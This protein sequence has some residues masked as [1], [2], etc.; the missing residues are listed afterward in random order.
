MTVIKRK[1]SPVFPSP[2]SGTNFYLNAGNFP[3]KESI[4]LSVNSIGGKLLRT[5]QFTTG[6]LGEGFAN[7][8]FDRKLSIGIYIINATSASGT[9][10]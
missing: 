3:K 7:V 9:L 8:T 10:Y 1:Q 6:E 4:L 5:L 2:D